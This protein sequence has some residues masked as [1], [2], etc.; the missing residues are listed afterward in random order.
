MSLENASIG[1]SGIRHRFSEKDRAELFPG[2]SI[3]QLGARRSHSWSFDQS[4]KFTYGGKWLD[5]FVRNELK[6]NSEVTR[7]EE[8]PTIV[9]LKS[10]QFALEGGLYVHTTKALPR[11][12]FLAAPRYDTQPV[13]PRVAFELSDGS[14]LVG[15]H[16]RSHSLAL[17]LGP[18]WEDQK[19]WIEGGYQF[20]RDFKALTAFV[21][22]PGAVL[23]AETPDM[24]V[25]ECV[26]EKSGLTPPLIT[27]ESTVRTNTESRF[28]HGFFLNYKL[29]VPLHPRLT[30]TV[31]N[32][33]QFFFTLA[34][35]RPTDTRYQDL[36]KQSLSVPIIGNLYF[37]PR[38]ELFLFQNKVQR[39]RFWQTQYSFALNYKFDWF[40]GIDW[41]D[42]MRY[43]K[44]DK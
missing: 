38:F 18:R 40:E 29:V 44:P 6:F 24:T 23:C 42:A 21:F 35:D 20:G 12:V 16:R 41:W 5:V 7:Q 36:I 43:K 31:G 30:Y 14:Q 10:N 25:K 9:N 2:I 17:K 33:G 15:R 11:L 32:E 13:S 26:N 28:R 1:F 19:S 8:G 34:G 39:T 27:P 4:A 37:E 22:D 3:P